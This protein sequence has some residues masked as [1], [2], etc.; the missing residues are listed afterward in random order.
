MYIKSNTMKLF[1]LAAA[2]MTSA[3]IATSASATAVT[4]DYNGP[5]AGGYKSV[6]ISKSPIGKTF[7]SVSAG[8]FGMTDTSGLL[9]DFVA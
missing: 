3:I 6:T 8:G 1:Q 5:S 9:G 7:S 4:L 2:A